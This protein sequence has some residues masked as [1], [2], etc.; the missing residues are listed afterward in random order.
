M[1]MVVR[2]TGPQA[3]KQEKLTLAFFETFQ[4]A[5][6]ARVEAGGGPNAD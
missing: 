4:M 5:D 2:I 6:R 3:E 1:A